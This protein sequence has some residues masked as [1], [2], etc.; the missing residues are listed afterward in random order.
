MTR[1]DMITPV[2][3]SVLASPPR[4]V[5]PVVFEPPA[6]TKNT[7]SA[8]KEKKNT[9]DK[10]SASSPVIANNSLVV[11]PPTPTVKNSTSAS[12]TAKSPKPPRDP[13]AP[14]RPPSSFLLFMHARR[15]QVK[16]ANP[17]MS[18]LDVTRHIGQMWETA[19]KK[20]YEEEGGRLLEVY[21]KELEEYEGK[22]QIEL[23]KASEIPSELETVTPAPA[24]AARDTDATEVAA[25]DTPAAVKSKPSRKTKKKEELQT[26]PEVLLSEHEKPPMIVASPERVKTIVDGK[27]KE[28][29]AHSTPS[30][31]MHHRTPEVPSSTAKKSPK[32]VASSPDFIGEKGPLVSASAVSAAPSSALFSSQELTSAATPSLHLSVTGVETTPEAPKLKK[33]KKEKAVDASSQPTF[34][35]G[36]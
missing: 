10:E 27:S 25:I 31:Q 2:A 15:E 35:V 36:S 13:R 29:T 8:A 21:R 30:Q 24:I 9:S 19:D 22:K 1:D 7:R 23:Q 17:Q 34:A 28:R 32:N 26:A 4:E 12:I 20:Q 3:T 5:V 18:Y 6:A 14:K 33:K 11:A 16:Q